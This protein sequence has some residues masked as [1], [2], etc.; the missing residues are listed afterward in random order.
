MS[1]GKASSGD[2]S[3]MS[4]GLEESYN[5]TADELEESEIIRE[6]ECH[7][8]LP[9]FNQESGG[10]QGKT[11]SGEN[12]NEIYY[13][14]IIDILQQ[15]NLIKRGEN[16]FKTYI[17]GQGKGKISSVPPLEYAKRFIKFFSDTT[18]PQLSE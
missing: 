14:G 4:D 3:M 8:R 15:Y 18:D 11:P 12:N 16:I 10:Y 7:Q 1:D 17:A 13:F 9:I 6:P 2:E 5:L